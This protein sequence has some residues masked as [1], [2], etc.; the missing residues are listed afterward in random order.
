MHKQ[1]DQAYKVYAILAEND[2]DPEAFPVLTR[3]EFYEKL[4]NECSDEQRYRFVA[5][6]LSPIIKL[7][8]SALAGTMI[9]V[10]EIRGGQVAFQMLTDGDIDMTPKGESD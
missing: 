1:I 9:D 2:F 10:A 4:Y 7:A 6:L 3:D 8:S 5:L